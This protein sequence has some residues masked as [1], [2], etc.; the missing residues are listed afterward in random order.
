MR[1][2]PIG[3]P[4]VIRTEWLLTST[5]L[6][7][8]QLLDSG[9]DMV[10]LCPGCHYLHHTRHTS[11]PT[12]R[13]A[14]VVT[15]CMVCEGTGLEHVSCVQDLCRCARNNRLCPPCARCGGFCTKKGEV[16]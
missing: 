4:D 11:C 9:F 14:P 8:R 1:L 13:F 12:C 6:F 16:A 10:T 5:E 3:D 15:L 2:R 7:A